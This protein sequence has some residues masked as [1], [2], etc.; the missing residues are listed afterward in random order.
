MKVKIPKS[1][2]L[3]SSSFDHLIFETCCEGARVY[4]LLL[5]LGAV[6]CGIF[7]WL[8]LALFHS[9]RNNV[10]DTA[11]TDDTVFKRTALGE[12]WSFGQVL[13]LATFAPVVL[14]LIN[15]IICE[16]NSASP[17]HQ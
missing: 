12:S 11:S 15:V 3:T 9:Y 16:S 10:T 6:L 13:A 2:L 4:E 8:L 14:D 5:L 7:M 1:T 17:A